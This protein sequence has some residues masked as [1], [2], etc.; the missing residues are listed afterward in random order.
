MRGYEPAARSDQMEATTRGIRA[1]PNQRRQF[2]PYT[3]TM[4]TRLSTLF[5]NYRLGPAALGATTILLLRQL[6]EAVVFNA[7]GAMNVARP[8]HTATFLSSGKVLV[9]GG[10]KEQTTVYET[11]S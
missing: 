2:R 9:V 1:H 4:R 11:A 3:K 7:T 5:P 10:S 8:G 6:A